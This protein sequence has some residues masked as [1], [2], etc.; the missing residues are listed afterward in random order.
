MGLFQHDDQLY[1]FMLER[2]GVRGAIVRLSGTWGAVSRQASYPP[3]L[4]RI[5]GETLA[6]SALFTSHIKAGTSL[7]IQL[8]AGGPLTSLFT[9]CSGEGEL[10]GLAHWREPLP[11]AL[12]LPDLQS[13]AHLAITLEQRNGQRYQGMV[14]LESA[15]L[16]QAFE[17]YFARSEQLPTRVRLA[18]DGAHSVGIMIQLLP[19]EG[20]AQAEQDPDGWQRSNLLLD[21]LGRDELLELDPETVLRRLFHEE[22]VRLFEGRPLRFGCRCSRDKVEQMLR[23]LGPAETLP[24]LDEHGHLEVTCEFCNR[25]YRFDRVDLDRIHSQSAAPG[26][27]TRQ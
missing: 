15:T 2:A 11:E 6:A 19:A 3:A 9:E 1:R 18:A 20:G 16:D 27:E 23:H 21:T 13:P 24:A 7:S 26:T 17:A 10:R 8:R 12:A 5:L 4:S 25:Q 22:N 14:P